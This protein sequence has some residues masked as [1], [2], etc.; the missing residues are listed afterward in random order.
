MNIDGTYNYE[1]FHRISVTASSN[2]YYKEKKSAVSTK[3]RYVGKDGKIHTQ[4]AL[5]KSNYNYNYLKLSSL[6]KKKI[7]KYLADRNVKLGKSS[8]KKV[9][10]GYTP[11]EGKERFVSGEKNRVEVIHEKGVVNDNWSRDRT[12][13]LFFQGVTD[14]INKLPIEKRM[15]FRR[16]GLNMQTMEI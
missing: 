5:R 9:K 2:L 3:S 8:F 6:E 4:M 16:L 7:D 10:R 11:I 1:K 13:V 14:E 15:R 12:N